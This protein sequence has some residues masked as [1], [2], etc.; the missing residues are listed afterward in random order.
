ME[1]IQ[2]FMLMDWEDIYHKAF[3]IYEKNPDKKISIK[4][5]SYRE[6]RSSQQNRYL[7]WVV[8]KMIWDDVWYTPEEV[9]DLMKI[10]FLRK[11]EEIKWKKLWRITSTIKLDTKHM[12]DYIENIRNRAAMELGINIP[13]P[14][15]AEYHDYLYTN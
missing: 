7:R 15:E 8:Y 13:S 6:N 1:L 14:D 11:V 9:H 4:I 3:K 12:T 2:D 5:K 10:K